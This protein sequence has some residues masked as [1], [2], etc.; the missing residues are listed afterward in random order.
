MYWLFQKNCFI[1]WFAF[2][3]GDQQIV[4]VHRFYD[5]NITGLHT[6]AIEENQ[7]FL[8]DFLKWNEYKYWL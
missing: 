7:S 8:I 6:A 3:S 1:F 5:E 4:V 2:F